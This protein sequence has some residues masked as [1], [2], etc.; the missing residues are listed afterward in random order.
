[1]NGSKKSA[2][3]SLITIIAFAATILALVFPIA[4]YLIQRASGETEI[5][6]QVLSNDELTLYAPEAELNARFSYAGEDVA[7]LWKAEVR[8]INSGYR[9]VVGKGSMKNIISDEGL[10]FVYPENTRILRVQEKEENLE[11]KL[12]QTGENNFQV[13]FSQWRA[14]EYVLACFYIAS[15]ESL[16]VNPLPS[17]TEREI[18]DGNVIIEDF[19]KKDVGERRYAIDVVLKGFARYGKIMGGILSGLLIIAIFVTILGGWIGYIRIS[20]WKKKYSEEVSKEVSEHLSKISPLITKE[21][22]NYY[23]VEPDMIPAKFWKGFK[24]KKY[25]SSFVDLDFDTLGEGLLVSVVLIVLL[26]GFLS[27]LLSII[28]V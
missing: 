18:I 20:S 9:T 6:A 28:P 17:V 22:M 7:H 24:G 23:L 3:I 2:R 15:E 19:T 8:F 21:E 16:S 26:V 1:M 10:N 25:P 13:Q 11:A 5:S 4:I 12:I 27:L 14:N